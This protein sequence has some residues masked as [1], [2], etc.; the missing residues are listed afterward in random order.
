VARY[1]AAHFVAA[2]QQVGSFEVVNQ[3]G[4]LQKNGGN[5]ASYFCTPDGRVLHSLTGPASAEELLAEARWAV[6]L[7]RASERKGDRVAAAHRAAME[8][9]MLRGRT[10]APF[11]VHRLL[12]LDPL[13]A[14]KD[15]YRTIFADI[16][17]QRLGQP[18]TELERAQ[19]AFSAAGRARLPVLLILHKGDRSED[20]LREWRRTVTGQSQSLSKPLNDLAS[21]Y[22]VVALPLSE[23]AALS[24]R[25]GVSPYAAPD[26]G[27]PLFVITRSNARQLN[28]VTT[29]DKPDDLAYAL[30]QGTVQEAKEH[31]RSIPQLRA[32]LAAV[33]PLDPGLRNQVRGLLA[34]ANRRMPRGEVAARRRG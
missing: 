18:E 34:E 20:V 13:P 29:W 1:F 9:L 2:H 12:A 19:Q 11:Q 33:E 31:D 26:Q 24:R 21:C 7:E 16:L 4:N 6:E 23:L 27:S 10:G 15:V 14:L 8:S 3:F 25:L 28:A 17:G 22:V 5:V 30:A 32:L